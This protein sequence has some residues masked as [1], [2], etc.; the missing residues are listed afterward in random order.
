MIT[1]V[2]PSNIPLDNVFIPAIASGL[3]SLGRFEDTY[4]VHAAKGETVIPKE[5]LDANPGLK[6]KLFQQMIDMGIE[7]PE[8]Y[9]V[10]ESLN[11]INPVTGQPEFFWNSIK[12]FFRSAAPVIGGIIGGYFG[13]V[14]AAVGSGLGSKL[15]GQSTEQALTTA[16][17]SGLGSYYFGPGAGAG[18]A[19]PGTSLNAAGQTITAAQAAAANAAGATAQQIAAG[20]PV[21]GSLGS[22]AVSGL[23]GLAPNLL[24]SLTNVGI[25]QAAGGGLGALGSALLTEE[26]ETDEDSAARIAAQTQRRTGVGDAIRRR[27]I[28]AGETTSPQFPGVPLEEL[29]PEQLDLLR[30]RGLN[31]RPT[32]RTT[33]ANVVAAVP[34]AQEQEIINRMLAGQAVTQQQFPLDVRLRDITPTRLNAQQ[35]GSVPGSRAQNQ[36]TVP[37]MLTPGEFVFTQ[38]AV[39]GASPN[40][41][42]QQQVRAMYDIMRG[43]EGRA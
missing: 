34:S 17:L 3:A 32:F 2:V 35:G 1:D 18:Q 23:K 5:V 15:A 25:A 30:E 41:S 36:D 22:Q 13:P 24:G 4:M 28:A 9:V 38:D 43:L 42:R 39:R 12:S 19:I 40:G 6:E 7:N 31:R 33:P 21:L 8:R 10:G 29:S 11:S 20:T 16:A 27:A 14:G 37:A 26:G